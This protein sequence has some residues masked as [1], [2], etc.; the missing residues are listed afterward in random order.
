M[1]GD[2]SGTVKGVNRAQQPASSSATGAHQRSSGDRDTA[3][4]TAP[5]KKNPVCSHIVAEPAPGKAQP[6]T[7]PADDAT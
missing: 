5:R 4:I 7:S 1:I 6:G 2:R 3:L